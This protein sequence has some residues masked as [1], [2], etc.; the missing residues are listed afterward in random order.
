M[1]RI[2]ASIK[3]RFPT[4]PDAVLVFSWC[5]FLIHVWAILNILVVLPSW[6]L[7]LGLFELL[8]VTA[9]PLAFALLESILVWLSLVFLSV[10]LPRVLLRADFVSQS[11]T[12]FSILAVVSALLHFYPEL[13]FT[14]RLYVLVA[15]VMIFTSAIYLS[16]LAGRAQKYR[17]FS[18]SVLSRVSVLSWVYLCLDLLGIAT[19]LIRN[20][21]S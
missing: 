2:L 16:F 11:A 8:G 1:S 17:E 6:A 20:L 9:Y 14:Y 7:R 19:I 5:V 21:S 10:L 18:R 4:R 3:S 13:V 12:F 15:L